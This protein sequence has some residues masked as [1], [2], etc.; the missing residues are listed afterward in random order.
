[1]HTVRE[2]SPLTFYRTAPAVPAA[3]ARPARTGDARPEP[4][5]KKPYTRRRGDVSQQV[6]FGVQLAFLLIAVWVGAQFYLWV[7]YYETAGATIRVSRPPGVEAWL[8]IAALMN[9]KALLLTWQVPAIHAAGMFMLIAFLAMSFVLRKSF[10]GWVC[11]VG[12]IS[13]WLWQAGRSIFGRTFALP[14]WADIPLRSLKYILFG[15][16]FYVVVTMPVTAI[17]EFLTSPYGLVADVKMLDF[18]RRMGQMTAIVLA[19]L[20]V[21]SV[22]VKNFWCRFLCPYGAMTG[23]VALVSPTRIRRDPV[24]C[25]D[26][27]KCAKACPA[28]LPVDTA[29]SIRSAEC[30]ACMS[31]VAVC[32][33]AGALDL[34]VGLGRQRNLQPW[35]V[36]TGIAVIFLAIVGYA[37]LTGHWH[38]DLPDV[39]YFDLIPKASDFA[40]PG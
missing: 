31:C 33:A 1:M 7:R 12:T 29:L 16:F 32:P 28:G 3:H 30:T 27:E 13:E 14:R 9:T 18:F 20:V 5:A 10:C 35:M 40:H 25:I 22:F 11:P 21:L 15:L 26:C 37:R 8:P 19:V 24:A 36:A 6:R 4:R 23:L 17:V 2:P 38:T 39:L 34:T